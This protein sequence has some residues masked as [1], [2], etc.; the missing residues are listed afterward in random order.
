MARHRPVLAA[1]LTLTPLVTLTL[2]LP[3]TALGFAVDVHR[4]LADRALRGVVEPGNLPVP[5]ESG[6][7]AFYQWL[8]RAMATPS[9]DPSRDGDD[10]QRFQARYPSPRD[11]H[12][13]AVRGFLALTQ[14]Q[15]TPIWGLEVFDRNEIIDRFNTAV[16]GTGYPDE[17][18]RNQN[19]FAYDDKGAILKLKDG[20][21]VPAD[22]M[23]LNMGHA[24]GLSSQAHAHYQL[25]ATKPSS[26]PEV[27]QKEPWNFVVA[28]GF[29]GPANQP[30]QVETYAAEMAQI[31]LDMAILARTWG[32]A[33]FNSTGE[34]LGLVWFAAG[35]HYLQ[36]VAGP[37]HTVQVGSY[38]LFKR[39]K[40]AY[41]LQALKTGGGTWAPLKSFPSIGLDFLHN[42]HLFAEQWLAA[43]LDKLDAGKPVAPALAAAWKLA[44]EDDKDFLDALGPALEAHTTG[45]FT[46]QP[47]ED[48]QG[49]GTILVRTLA[50]LASRDGA[51]LYEAALLA[52][53]PTLTTVG[54]VLE[55]EAPLKPEWVGDPTDPQVAG[56]LETMA[57]LHARSI[58]RA[59]T[60]T[61]LYWKAYTEGSPDAAARRLRRSR[62]NYL[63]AM[64]KRRAAYLAN[65]PPAAMAEVNEPVWAYAEVGGLA[66]LL[67]GAW[68]VVAR[69]RRPRVNSTD[70]K[71]H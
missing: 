27:L 39:A 50:R 12:A 9:Q 23:I 62:L 11:F 36:D 37:L 34:Y 51:Q 40:I 28:L 70:Q 58:R 32:E 17:D 35:L 59:T 8:G 71:V 65:P 57:T 21:K 29:P 44:N 30:P 16:F 43:E 67:G 20:R 10:P 41:Y 14:E 56:A 55:D 22:P 5:T 68:L 45:L 54:V 66:L 7:V 2:L 15:D 61:R 53:G 13:R 33:E 3:A 19:R 47:W 18:R 46:Q 52:G 25:V 1:L 24:E 6:M 48:L 4:K 31:H 63:E 64:E 60:A 26:D 42:H 69:K 38:E 49:G